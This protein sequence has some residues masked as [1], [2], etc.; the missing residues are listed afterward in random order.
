MTG[1]HIHVRQAALSAAALLLLS[2]ASPLF[3]QDPAPS[4]PQTGGWRKVGDPPAAPANAPAADPKDPEPIAQEMAPPPMDQ[5]E[6]AAPQA[7]S[8]QA[9]PARPA[10]Q[11]PP[12]GLPPQLTVKPG[13]FI[14]VR[15]NDQLSSD[16]NQPGDAF[17]AVLT[18]PLV[19]DGVVVAQRGQTVYGRVAEAQKAHAGSPSKLGLELTGLTLVD[20]LQ[21]PLRS[22]MVARQGGTTPGRDQAGTVIS[23]TAIGAAVGAMADWGRGAAIGA[24]AG[25]AAGAVA[26]LLTRNHPTVVYPETA[27]TFRIDAPIL[28][29][30]TRAPQAFRYVDPNEYDRP[31]QVQ[32]RPQLER[33]GSIWGPGYYPYYPYYPY[34]Y[35][36][37]Y[38]GPGWGMGVGVIVNRG[39]Y[40]RFRR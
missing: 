10:Y 5:R 30:T 37:P 7:R 29:S 35:W 3:S 11:A 32:T 23:T 40:H 28:V 36:G 1:I 33:R 22:Q 9:P 27:L 12:Y 31:M 25:A 4:T 19:V 14:T 15:T 38:W 8:E 18:Q 39:G 16:R 21:V 17:S 2:A 34:S 13:T 26:V 6:P 20:G 24:G